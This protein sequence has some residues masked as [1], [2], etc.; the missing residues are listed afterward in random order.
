MVGLM[1]SASIRALSIPCIAST[2]LGGAVGAV[3]RGNEG[4][5]PVGIAGGL[6]MLGSSFFESHIGM[7]TSESVPSPTTLPLFLGGRMGCSLA[8]FLSS[9]VPS[10]LTSSSIPSSP[11]WR[12]SSSSDPELAWGA[13][14]GFRGAEDCRAFLRS[15]LRLRYLAFALVFVF[16]FLVL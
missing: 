12:S 5:E 2:D 13:S 9:L 1:I 3:G 16:H 6:R 4:R 15:F 10:P 7:L 11:S 14:P 8:I